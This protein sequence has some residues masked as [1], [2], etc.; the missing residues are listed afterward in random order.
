MVSCVRMEGGQKGLGG[1]IYG[2]K[3]GSK[4]RGEGLREEVKV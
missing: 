1:R 2:K 3:T 4:G